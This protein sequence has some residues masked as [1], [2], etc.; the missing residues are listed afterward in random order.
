MTG[1]TVPGMV[2]GST[3]LGQIKPQL[4]WEQPLPTRPASTSR[5]LQPC[6]VR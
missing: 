4:P 2:S 6:C 5:T 1:H 3:W